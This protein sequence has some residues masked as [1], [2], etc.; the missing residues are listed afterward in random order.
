MNYNL[1]NFCENDKYAVKSYC[2]IHDV[3]ES[4][5]LGDI[6][7]VNIE[8]LPTNIDLITHGSPCFT[9]D[10]L[11]LTDKGYKQISDI[12]VGDKVIDHTNSYNKVLNKFN[13]GQ[14]EIWEI[15]AMGSDTIKT[16]ENHKFYVRNIKRVWDNDVRK[17]VKRFAPPEWIEANKLSKE[18]YLG[19]AINQNNI[20]P[21]WHGVEDNRKGHTKPI[22]SLDMTNKKLWYIIGRFLGDGWTRRRKERN[23][24]LSGVII[25]CGKHKAQSFE[26]ELS[27]YLNYTKV[28]DRTVY[29]Y[30]FSNKELAVFC[31]QF[32]H[33]AQNKFIPGFVFDMPTNLLKELLRGYFESDGSINVMTGQ[34]KATSISR[35]LIYGIAQLVA[36]VYHRPYSIYFCRRPSIHIIENRIVNQNHSYSFAF[37]IN[38]RERDRAFYEDGYLWVPINSVINTHNFENV[39]DIEVENTHSFTANGV[40]VHNCQSFSIS[41]KQEGGIKDSGTRSSLL[42]NSVEII[43]HC[44]PKFVIWENVKNVLSKK[45]RPVFNDYICT[46]KENGYNT[47]YKVLNALDYNIPQNR[48]RIYA[49]SIREDIDKNPNYMVNYTDNMYYR[50]NLYPKPLKFTKPLYTLLEQNVDKKYFLSDKLLNG[51]IEHRNRHILK[52]NGFGFR[53]C[54]DVNSYAHT[55]TT[56]EGRRQTDTFIDVKQLKQIGFIK[57]NAQGQRVYDENVACTL[58]ANGGGLGAKTGLYLV[59]QVTKTGYAV[60]EE[61]NSINLDQ[62]NSKTRRGRVGNQRANTLTTSCNQAVI[63]YGD[64]R[65]LTPRECWR[66]MGFDDKDFDKASNVDIGSRK[67]SDSQLYK[68]AGNS[69][70]VNVLEEIY[71][72]LMRLYPNDFK[73]DMNI[74]S[75]FSGIGAFEKALKQV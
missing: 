70:V 68:Q 58:Q 28:E 29:K 57:N 25:C 71:K 63:Q 11:V 18:Y 27:G 6:T 32:G 75:L 21:E 10:T 33:G 65:R 23:N 47:Y 72:C 7:Q 31:E 44:K 41:G 37:N 67:M 73:Q 39:Y 5:N 24:N 40:I 60:A 59:K 38:K 52:G 9:A 16:T 30:Q 43:K 51:F 42:W 15:N 66:L 22:K 50:N 62:P 74:I 69:I 64:I 46:M 20:L 61:G 1:I 49:I 36:K 53:G 35:K 45:H 55:L 8:S 13:Q 4:L 56:R 14:K 12:E 34:I 2:A 54:T 19:I 48:E 17:K 26:K 3:N